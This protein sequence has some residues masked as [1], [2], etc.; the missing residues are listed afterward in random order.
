MQKLQSPL[1]AILIFLP[2]LLQADGWHLLVEPK[3]LGY[4]TAWPVS[5]SEKTVL[6]PARLQDGEPVA[7]TRAEVE[8]SPAAREQIL[9]EAA[10]N[11]S[12]VLA[13]LKPRYVRGKNQVIEYAVLESENPL[14]ASTVLAPDFADL[15][16]E[17]LGPDLLVAIPNRY[18][19]LVF[20][21]QS[22]AHT[23]A[24]DLVYAEYQGAEHPVSRELFEIRQGKLIAIGQYR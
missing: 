5:G 9:A 24:S 2:L 19:V 22:P 13:T 7:L 6:V 20:P 16:A 17:T 15:F 8:K 4:E 3:F 1:C 11:A 18:L 23:G 21:K 12:A 10:R 14:T